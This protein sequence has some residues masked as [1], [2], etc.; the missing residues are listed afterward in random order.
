MLVVPQAKVATEA[1]CGPWI[2]QARIGIDAMD[3]LGFS[4]LGG[5][6]RH[7]GLPGLLILS[8]SPTCTFA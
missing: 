6:L 7:P 4:K 1:H 8:P 2:W 3:M 5:C